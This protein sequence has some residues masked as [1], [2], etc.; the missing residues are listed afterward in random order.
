MTTKKPRERVNTGEINF[1]LGGH[2]GRTLEVACPNCD[3][4]FEISTR[5]LAELSQHPS[6]HCSVCDSVFSTEDDDGL[7]SLFAE[8]RARRRREPS[9]QETVSRELGVSTDRSSRTDLSSKLAASA[10]AETASVDNRANS[11]FSVATPPV[12]ARNGQDLDSQQSSAA[13]SARPRRDTSEFRYRFQEQE[14][15]GAVSSSRQVGSDRSD[16]SGR[17]TSTTTPAATSAVTER[18][19]TQTVAIPTELPQK[20]ATLTTLSGAKLT[21]IEPEALAVKQRS[22]GEER[23]KAATQYPDTVR[24][25]SY[26]ASL[27]SDKSRDARNNVDSTN[28]RSLDRSA[29]VNEQPLYQGAAGSSEDARV[30]YKEQN[31]GQREV[32][33]QLEIDF[34]QAD[35][36]GINLAADLSSSNGAGATVTTK[37]NPTQ[38]SSANGHGDLNQKVSSSKETPALLRDLYP[39]QAVTS[40]YLDEQDV[41]LRS[42]EGSQEKDDS[43]GFEYPNEETEVEP[44]FGASNLQVAKLNEDD[45]SLSRTSSDR[46]SNNTESVARAFN[47]S[48]SDSAES[49]SAKSA[50]PVARYQSGLP[51][52]RSLWVAICCLSGLLLLPASLYIATSWLGAGPAMLKLIP[53]RMTPPPDGLFISEVQFRLL[54]LEDQEKLAV[55]SGSVTNQSEGVLSSVLLEAT[56]FDKAGGALES[57]RSYLSIVPQGTRLRSMTREI[58][59][60]LQATTAKRRIHLAP[61]ETLKFNIALLNTPSEQISDYNIRIISAGK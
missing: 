38:I 23:A 30:D 51:A 54:D 56:A 25:D 33:E 22:T 41:A 6:F 46:E 26:Q 57:A 11:G 15:P 5:Q 24:S 40:S 27:S 4:R 37:T 2:S 45:Y 43:L 16:R 44:A 14:E 42:V 49:A 58:F 36:G 1:A 8:A 34:E 60:E 47:R 10:L 29:A 18:R 7:N 61:G 48:N 55:V 21:Y 28:R 9:Q 39:E 53:G 13:L 19:I 17:S 52:W 35:L 32:W 12:T 3:A 59:S 20:E 50:T 31:N